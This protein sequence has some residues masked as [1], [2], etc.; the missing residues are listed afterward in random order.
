MSCLREPSNRYDHYAVKV[1]TPET[2][3]HHLLDA[4]TRDHQPYQAVR[5]IVGQKMVGRVPAG[6]C[7]ILSIGMRD[8]FI[9]RVVCVYRGGFLHGGPV[10]GGGPKLKVGYMVFLEDAG[11]R[12]EDRHDKLYETAGQIKPFLDDQNDICL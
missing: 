12:R 7:K 8:G 9:R 3:A 11:D 4:V 1:I 2:V 5:D 10:A 6:L